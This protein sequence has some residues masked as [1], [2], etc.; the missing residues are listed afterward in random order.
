M[1]A[2]TATATTAAAAG[3]AKTTAIVSTMRLAVHSFKGGTGKSTIAANMAVLLAQQG[4]R[5]GVVDLDLA[6]PGL[7]VLFQVGKEGLRT[8]NDVLLNRCSP[9]DPV[10]DLT[11]KCGLDRG[12]LLFIPASYKAED[13]VRILT[14]GYELAQFR[15]I[16]EQIAKTHGLDYLLIDTHPGI[17]QS[18]LLAIGVCDALVLVSRIDSQDLFG[19]GIVLEIAK[20]LNKPEIFVANMVPP[21]TNE[22]RV[23]AK[24]KEIFG[25]SMVTAIPFYPEILRSLSSSV[26]VIEHPEHEF[27]LCLRAAIARAEEIRV[28]IKG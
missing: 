26:F 11:K 28:T 21:G 1:S 22:G 18:T 20:T 19:T 4:K 5:V 15:N 2:G 24:I 16:I 25:S 6:G 8:L 13:I 12:S 17:E 27:A 7:H 3:A 14:R 9:L 10:I 23:R